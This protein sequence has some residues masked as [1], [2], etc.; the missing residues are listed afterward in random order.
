MALST[1]EP[2]ELYGLFRDD[3]LD[4]TPSH[5]LDTY[6]TERY[7]SE[8]QDIVFSKLPARDRKMAPFVL[9]SEQGKPIFGA[10]G[11]KVSAWTP[12]YIKPKDAVRPEDART[13]RP[14]EILGQ[15]LNLQQRFDLRVAEVVEYHKQA[16]DN[17]LAW[18]AARAFIDGQVVLAYERDFSNAAASFPEV[19]LTFGRAA[20]HT[21]SLLTNE[22]DDPTTDILGDISTWAARMQNAEHGG[23]PNRLYLGANVAQHFVKNNGIRDLLD[24]R[25]RGAEENEF[26]RGLMIHEKPLAYI[27]R[28]HPGLEVYTYKDT[29][30]Q[31]AGTQV[32]LLNPNDV[33]LVAPG[34]RGVVAY[35]AIYDADAMIGGDALQ[36]D[37]FVKMW[38]NP[39]PGALYVMT[40][41]APLAIPL[42]PN[43]TLK[44]TVMS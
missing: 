31:N 19:T 22:W 35:G 38:H 33:L 43:R 12:P 30:E 28:L 24:T 14:S 6:F 40:Q 9:P 32:D 37:V 13:V 1:W 4:G 18:M 36:T 26:K 23:V 10:K 25:Y 42:Y 8:D 5:F 44:A 29:V 7:Y 11:E 17:R 39:D 15:R 20:N 41:S 34:A 21:V 3:R 16:I 27:G 2:H